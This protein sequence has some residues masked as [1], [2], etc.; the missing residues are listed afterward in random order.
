MPRRPFCRPFRGESSLSIRIYALSKQLNVD[1]KEI[2]DAIRQLGIEGKGSSLATLTDEE[3]DQ[4]KDRILSQ[5]HSTSSQPGGTVFQRPVITAAEKR[6]LNLDAPVKPVLPVK[7]EVFV[8]P[9]EP[10]EPPVEQKIEAAESVVPSEIVPPEPISEPDVAPRHKPLPVPIQPVVLPKTVLPPPIGRVELPVKGK[11]HGKEKQGREGKNRFKQHP[12]TDGQSKAHPSLP[13]KPAAPLTTGYAQQGHAT[14]VRTNPDYRGPMQKITEKIPNLDNY[15]HRPEGERPTGHKTGPTIHIAPLPQGA[16]QSR[17][18]KSREPIAQKPDMK[19][20]PELLRGKGNVAKSIE[21]HIRKHEERLRKKEEERKEREGGKKPAG[22]GKEDTEKK[23]RTKGNVEFGSGGGLY[24][25]GKKKRRSGATVRRTADD[26]DGVMIPRQL[27]RQK[28]HGKAVNTAAPRKG[29][30]VIQLPCTLRQFAEQTGLSVAMVIRKLLEMGVPMTLNSQLDR[31]S[32]ELL[33]EAF[34][35]KVSVREQVTLEDR[36]VTAL[37]EGE[38]PPES[39]RPRPPVVTVLGHVDHGKTTLLDYIL[40]LNVVSGEKGGITQHIRAYRVA[41]PN[42]EDITFVDTPGHEAF[43]EMRARGANCTDIVIL[44]V[45]ADD[46]V[47]PQTEEAISHAKAAGVPIVVALNKMDLPGVNPDR[48]IQE[49]AQHDLLPSEWGGDTEVIRCSGLT[50]MGVD[51]LL[52]TIQVIAEL[53]DLKANPDRPAIGVA[54][55]AELQAGQGVVCKMLVQR[56]TLRTGDVILCGSAYGRVK[57]MYDTL[58]PKKQIEEAMP[59]TPVQ[60][61]GLDVA[62]K[63]GSKFCVLD[64][65]SDARSI[66]EQRLAEERSDELADVQAHVTLE[67]LFQRMT[68]AQTVQ[69]LNIIIRADV[70]G[71]IEAIRKELGKLKHPEVQIKILQATV[72]GITEADVQLADASDAIIVGFSVVPDENARIMAERKKVQIRR[73]DI[74]YNLTDDIKKAL[75]GMLKPIEQVKE[76]GRAMVQQVFSISRL[77]TIAG[78]RVIAGIIE[79][80][81]RIRVIRENRIIG[82]YPLDSLKR[83]KDDVKEVRDGYECGI[84]LK[85]FNDLKEGDI[86]EAYKIESIARTF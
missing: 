2:L 77:G 52:E 3:V 57:A 1:S 42:G 81:C 74:I 65:V 7:T 8:K 13:Q 30:I 61:V 36:L 29:D 63:A 72:G 47:M 21:E 19:L 55:E 66:A 16:T 40:H 6:V 18:A 78:C 46:G 43:T 75:E 69:T 62:P 51:K 44:V 60:L 82:E 54:L 26:D 39:L 17:P 58:D 68:H 38:E 45:A 59:S 28:V 5:K 48:V 37:F 27:K 31:E 10:V 70:R 9:P 23:V 12:Q 49:L 34:D 71:S 4:V 80:D 41:M 35:I 32:S 50:G 24:E 15:R 11:K 73:Y 83:I 22:K 79:R 20:P 67:T 33:A 84:K 85:G 56:G 25:P 64:D 53:N 86:L 14:N 76:L